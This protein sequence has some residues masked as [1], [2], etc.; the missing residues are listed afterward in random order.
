[1]SVLVLSFPLGDI[2]A[3]GKCCCRF[4]AGLQTLGLMDEIRKNPDVMSVLFTYT[5]PDPLTASSVGKV[6]L[7]DLSNADTNRGRQERKTM[8]FWAD[9]LQD[10]EGNELG[11]L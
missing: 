6:F 4:T 10:L 2:T 11:R 3:V 5:S 8:V 1:M 7:V 9:F